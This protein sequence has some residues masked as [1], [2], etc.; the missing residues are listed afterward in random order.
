M[1]FYKIKELPN[2]KI[3]IAT[4]FKL[5]IAI[6]V[7]DRRY[8][9]DDFEPI[10]E[11]AYGVELNI[12]KCLMSGTYLK[13]DLLIAYSQHE[14]AIHVSIVEVRDGNQEKLIFSRYY[15]DEI[16]VVREMIKACIDNEDDRMDLVFKL[17]N[18][19]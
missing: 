11:L 12:G 13:D 8:D 3:E 17:M 19:K 1:A 6:W 10:D 2:V 5:P 7:D 4:N 16:D 9:V 15:F 18:I 14:N